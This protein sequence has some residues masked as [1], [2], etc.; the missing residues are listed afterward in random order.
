MDFDFSPILESWRFLLGGLGVTVAAVGS[1]R[2]APASCS[3]LRSVSARVY[4][5]DWL[6]IPL[7]FYIDS[8][9]AIP[10]LVVLVWI[11]LRGADPVGVIASSPFWAALVGA[12]AAHRGLCRR[13]RARRHRLDPARARCGPGSRSACRGAQVVRKIVLP[14]AIVRMLPAFGSILSITI[15]D[16]AIATVIAVPE[17]MK[18]AETLAG[19]TYR[20]IEIFTIVD[21]RLFHHPLPDHAADRC[22]LPARRASGAVMNLDWSDRLA[23]PRRLLLRRRHASPSLLTVLTMVIA[24]P[25][26]IVLALM[27]VSPIEAARRLLATGFVEFFRNLPLILVVYWAFYVMPVLT[28]LEL[29]GL[30][31]RPRRAVPERLGLQFR[32]L[33]RRHQLDPQGPDRGGRRRSA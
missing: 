15:K 4:G 11:Y 21:A 20:P 27:R 17:L 24:V 16:T 18:R 7:V 26:G 29:L 3:A 22:A 14:Q 8:M 6:R 12:H 32:D 2:S 28:G 31:H 23:V 9:R 1:P 10:V 13:D 19:Q 5:P 33:P 30:H 25:G